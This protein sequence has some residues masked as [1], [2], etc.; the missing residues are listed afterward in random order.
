MRKSYIPVYTE[1]QAVACDFFVFLLW[2]LKGSCESGGIR[3]F[4]YVHVTF[5]LIRARL[6]CSYR[7]TLSIRNH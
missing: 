4:A 1:S 3:R 7:S 6:T 5:L 2:K